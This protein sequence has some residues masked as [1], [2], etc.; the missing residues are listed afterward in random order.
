MKR[1]YAWAGG[2]VLGIGLFLWG[3][4]APAVIMRLTPLSEILRDMNYIFVAE[5]QAVYPDKPAAILAVGKQYKGKVP[6]TRI[7]VNLTGDTEAIKGKHTGKLCKRLAPRMHVLLFANQRGKIYTTFAFS[8][9]TWFQIKGRKDN[10]SDK[11]R[12][13]FTHCE[14]YLRRT[15]AGSSAQLQRIVRDGLAGKKK[16]PPPNP[17]AQPRVGPEIKQQKKSDTGRLQSDQAGRMKDE[18]EVLSFSSFILHPSSFIPLGVIPT[19]GLGGPLAILAILF[20]GL[21]GG[22][23]L[24]FR[25]WVPLLTVAG[26]N[27]TLLVIYLWFGR[28]LEDTWLGV[29]LDLWFIMTLVTIAGAIWSWHRQVRNMPAGQTS[30]VRPTRS[31]QV[32]LWV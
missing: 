11:V 14:P 20:P 3:S 22:A 15:F 4:P 1:R 29:P 6:F 12:W 30:G 31:E 10:D 27:S 21:F 24:V 19:L 18:A 8:N 17:K 32:I 9:G 2:L 5:V 7:P 25:S 23:L 26:V 13:A 28:S 16:P